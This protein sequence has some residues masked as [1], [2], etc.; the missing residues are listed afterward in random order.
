[1][2]AGP[3]LQLV[4]R[5]QTGEKVV[6]RQHRSGDGASQLEPGM[7]VSLEFTP[8]AGF[9]LSPATAVPPDQESEEATTAAAPET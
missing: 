8:R 1:M 7:E 4:V 9:L 5:T 3:E 6:S 2:V